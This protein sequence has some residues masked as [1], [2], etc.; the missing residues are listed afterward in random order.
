MS[1]FVPVLLFAGAGLLLGGCWSLYK[2]D[3]SRVVVAIVGLLAALALA[4]GI[5]W[6]VPG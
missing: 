4:A 5:A 6:L 1:T 2:Q 3:A